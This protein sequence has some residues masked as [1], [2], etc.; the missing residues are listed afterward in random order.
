MTKEIHFC[1]GH[2]LLDYEGKCR[3][4]HG[5]NGKVE[6]EVSANSLDH[7]GMVIDFGDISKVVKTW[8]DQELDHKMLLC[9]RDPMLEVLQE[10]GEPCFVMAENPTAENIAKLI[11]EYAIG[12]GLAVSEVRLWETATSYAVYRP[13]SKI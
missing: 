10:A 1:Y 2:R 11:C 12:R 3:H 6:I 7:R 8:I 5:H 13:H 4:L 9:R